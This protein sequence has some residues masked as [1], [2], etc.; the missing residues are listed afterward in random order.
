LSVHGVVLTFLLLQPGRE[1]ALSVV[2]N[3]TIESPPKASSKV[4]PPP[5][6]PSPA[7]EPASVPKASRTA[8]AEKP[9]AP[10]K[11]APAPVPTFDLGANTFAMEGGTWGLRPSEGDS[12][13]GAFEA[14]GGTRSPR[15]NRP[16]S[17]EKS[18]GFRPTPPSNMVRRPEPEKGD[19]SAPPYP[20]EAKRNGI[21]GAVL[22]RVEITKEGRVRS[23]LVVADPGGGLGAAARAAML[24]ERW[25][26]ALDR[27]GSPVDAVITYSYRFLLE[28]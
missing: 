25:K 8:A 26:P 15:D 21:E 1:H 9:E 24:D 4:M 16:E 12:M 14:P 13:L 23:V 27:N 19:I 6:P 5:P 22:L 10:K 2:M 17:S 3:L 11:P 7:P 18:R 28:G 20:A